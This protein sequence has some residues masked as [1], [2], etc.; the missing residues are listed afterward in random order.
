MKSIISEIVETL[1]FIL[2]LYIILWISMYLGVNLNYPYV[3]AGLIVMWVA[4]KMVFRRVRHNKKNLT[5]KN[6][7]N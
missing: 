2:V 5:D 3:F 6:S 1:L 7:Y 4:V